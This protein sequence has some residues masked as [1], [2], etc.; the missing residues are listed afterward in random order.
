[1]G[2]L[3]YI[4]TALRASNAGLS[5]RR[6]SGFLPAKGL[7]SVWTPLT[8]RGGAGGAKGA[9]EIREMCC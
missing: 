5:P 8:G 2:L 1:M 9:S 7:G 4:F 3:R 6:L